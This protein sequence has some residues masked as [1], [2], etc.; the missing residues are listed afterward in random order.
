MKILYHHRI[1]ADDGQAVHVREMI[2]ALRAAGHSVDECALVPKAEGPVA[3]DRS[4][5]STD[6]GGAFWRR[7]SLPRAA[8]EL[9]EIAYDRHGASRLRR[10][11]RLDRP[12]VV[13]E[14]HAL[15]CASGLRA[16]RTLGV[17]LLLEV[18][19]P[20]TD[21]MK[22]LGL[23]RFGWRARSIERKVLSGADAVLAVSGVLRDRLVE[24]GARPECT[25][26][27]RNGADPER[28]DTAAV[29]RAAQLRRELMLDADAFVL[30]FV[31][32]ARPWHRLDLAVEL[33][34]R[35]GFERAHLL[36]VGKGP[37]LAE[38]EQL[39]A[40][41]GVRSRLHLVGAVE[42]TELPAYVL[43]FDASLIPAINPYA[44]PL[45]A[46][47]ALV[48]GVPVVAPRQPNLE[49]L[50]DSGTDGLLYDVDTGA[51]GL[52]AQLLPLVSDRRV[53]ARLGDAGRARLRRER[54]TWAGQAERVVKLG[55]E[56][57]VSRGVGIT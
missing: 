42:P 41:A 34:A 16:A 26:I 35:S 7:L 53:A 14:R 2:G 11:G 4:E 33:L 1:R 13:Y 36:V 12:D 18:N 46:F 38:V 28:Y 55:Q 57:V 40:E 5:P 15:H 27:I 50:I 31:G 51:D 32:Y 49:E 29:D 19:S 10:A 25:H 6:G 22:A 17:P 48:A 30:G 3:V 52:A 37:A 39:A 44:S 20:M 24:L 9:L 54:W 47:D 21:E 43:S 23:L 45:K 56:L 8:T